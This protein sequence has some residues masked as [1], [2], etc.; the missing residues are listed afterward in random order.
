M[1]YQLVLSDKWNNKDHQTLLAKERLELDVRIEIA[2]VNWREK[3]VFGED[4]EEGVVIGY[5]W[6]IDPLQIQCRASL[7]SQIQLFRW[8]LIDKIWTVVFRET[9]FELLFGTDELNLSSGDIYCW[10]QELCRP[11]IRLHRPERKL[12]FV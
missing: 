5:G 2:T 8:K 6:N 10:E 1:V 7:R 3:S 9:F 12:P 4:E 11:D